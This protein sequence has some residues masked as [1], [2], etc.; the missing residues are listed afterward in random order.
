LLRDVR[1]IQAEKR[2][3]VGERTISVDEITG[4][5]AVERKHPDLPMLPKH[6]L[7]REFEEIR[8][9]TPSWFMNFDV[10]SGQVIEPSWGGSRNEEDGLAHLQHLIAK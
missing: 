2:A 7:R 4:V 10:V 1:S 5:Q 3:K 9:G 6:V 8:H